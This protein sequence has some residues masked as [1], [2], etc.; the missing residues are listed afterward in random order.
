LLERDF[1]GVSAAAGVRF[2]LWQ[3]G[4]F[5]TNF[6]SSYRAPALEEL[7]NN[8]PH[9]GTISFEI[10]NN[11][12][13]RER[14]NGVEFSFKQNVKR[15]RVDSSFFYYNISDFVFLA[16]VDEDNNGIIDRED[17]F[18][19]Q[20]YLQGNSRYIGADL[21]ADYDINKYVNV[22]FDGDIVKARLKDGDIPLP[23]ITPSRARIGVD[24][25]Y[26]GL[27]IRPEAL[28][29]SR[30][31]E[32]KIFPL[33]TPTAGYGVVNVNSSYTYGNEHLAHIITLSAFNLNNKLYRNHLSFIK[34]LAPEIG[35]GF[36][37]S[38][39]LRFF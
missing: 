29:A 6:N 23:R 27:S 10:G 37:A 32:G 20:R 36:R 19:V 9:V 7:Y 38:Y 18:P 24:L 30:K 17:G 15:L 25:R 39:T 14:S 26:Q 13:Q 35:R 33:E 28:F 11:A 16:P 1:T 31:S 3:G 2:R 12:L 8:G 4:S 5:I 21:R 22:F 34:D